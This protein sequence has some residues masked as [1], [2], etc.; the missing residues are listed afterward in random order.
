MQASFD[1]HKLGTGQRAEYMKTIFGGEAS[2]SAA[3]LMTA[4][5]TGKLDQLT[6]EFK[7]SDGKTAEL[8]QVMQDNLDG[9]LK[10]LQSAFEAIGTDLFDQNDG[11]LRTLTQD[12]AA[13]LLKVDG[14]IKA[15]PELQAVL[16]KW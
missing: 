2:S 14:W 15:N 7:A 16:Q 5:S 4:A 9:D 1:R 3:L 6:A 10:E 12:T 8:V 11:S 13:L